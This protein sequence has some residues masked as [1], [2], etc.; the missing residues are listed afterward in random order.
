MGK[1]GHQA[2]KGK[3]AFCEAEC[4]EDDYC[5]GCSTHVCDE[6]DVSC[7]EY[8]THH[9]PEDHRRTPEELAELA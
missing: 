8:G 5:Y 2:A 3:C 1:Q 9:E 7:G 4:T 6:C